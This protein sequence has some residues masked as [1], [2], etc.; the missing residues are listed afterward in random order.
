MTSPS[1]YAH[2]ILTNSFPV[3]KSLV[4]A[5]PSKVWLEFDGNLTQIP[6]KQI[7]FL[8]LTDSSGKAIPVQ[9]VY[10]GGARITADVGTVKTVGRIKVSWRVVSE[11]GHPVSGSIYFTISPKKMGQ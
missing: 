3:Q 11:D 6:G 4:T 1:A 7:N 10:V 2:A 5:M 8:D 9:R